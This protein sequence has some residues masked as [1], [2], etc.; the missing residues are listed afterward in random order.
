M[1]QHYFQ[2]I[3]FQISTKQE[4]HHINKIINGT[5]PTHPKTHFCIPP[6]KSYYDLSNSEEV[7]HTTQS[8]M[9]AI[10]YMEA[11]FYSYNAIEP[12]FLV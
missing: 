2:L 12:T 9:L 4:G 7:L 5:K 6:I 3:C 11:L 10:C 8:K 1:N